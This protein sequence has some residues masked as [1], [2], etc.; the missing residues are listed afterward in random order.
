MRWMG[1]NEIGFAEGERQFVLVHVQKVMVRS[2]KEGNVFHRSFGK[3]Q[4]VMAFLLWQQPG[5]K[6]PLGETLRNGLIQPVILRRRFIRG[7]LVRG[8]GTGRSKNYS[9]DKHSPDTFGLF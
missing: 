6:Q 9:S 1:W 4:R 7:M 8:M 5:F 3:N 2:D